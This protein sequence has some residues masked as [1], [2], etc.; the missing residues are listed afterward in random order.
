MLA[1]VL[2][3]DTK[4]GEQNGWIVDETFLVVY[5]SAY[6]LL[7]S[8]GQSL[9]E[10]AGIGHGEAGNDVRM[11]IGQT[12]IV[13]LAKQFVLVVLCFVMEKSF[14]DFRPQSKA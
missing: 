6:L 11:A 5:L 12:E 7:A 13:G 8:I 10:D 9:G 3:I 14:T 1:F 2:D 4:L